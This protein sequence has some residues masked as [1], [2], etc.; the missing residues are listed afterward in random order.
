MTVGI[1][2]QIDEKSQ[3]HRL[4]VSIEWHY[5][6]K[7]VSEQSEKEICGNGGKKGRKNC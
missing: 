4:K 6:G 3:T 1:L 7:S 2:G 5:M